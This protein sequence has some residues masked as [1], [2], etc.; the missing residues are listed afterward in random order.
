MNIKYLFLII[1]I[2]IIAFPNQVLAITGYSAL[3]TGQNPASIPELYPNQIIDF[4]VKFKNTGEQIWEGRGTKTVSLRTISGQKSKFLYTNWYNSYTPNKLN[5]VLIIGSNEES[6]FRFTLSAPNNLGMHWEKFNLFAGTNLISGGEIEI[7]IKV[8]SREQE[9]TA[10]TDPIIIEEEVIEIDPITKADPIIPTQTYYWQV[11]PSNI[12]IL[13]NHIW[14]TNANGPEIEIGLLFVEK[15]EKPDYLPFKISS[16]NNTSYDIYDQD[17]K[18]LVRNTSGELIEVDYDYSLN[19]YFLNSSDGQRILMTDSK[20]KLA[21]PNEE[22]IIF[23]I[24]SWQRGQFW[25]GGINDNEFRDKIEIKYNPNTERLWLVNE[26]PIEK[27]LRG[28]AEVTD[29][30]QSE[31]LKT[32]AIA[33]RTYAAFRLLTP[34]YTNTPD[35]NPFFTVR[36]TQADQVYRGYNKEKRAPNMLNAINLTKG[37]LAVYEND[38][39]LAYYFAQ[40]NGQTIASHQARMTNSPVN[41]LQSKIDPPGQGKQLIGHGVGLPQNSGITAASQGANYSQ[42]LKYYYSGIDL[43]RAY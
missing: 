28:L 26:L 39:I 14:P 30:T 16:L 12:N 8:V 21:S 22:E 29:N 43:N 19:R 7:G 5:P 31:F 15:Q 3:R 34:K 38:P 11:I 4:W 2:I 27:Y 41:Y 10:I 20:I 25:D 40:S 33:A 35:G 32:Q 1:F 17:N 24:D 36:A 18:L 37:I 6:I 23:K 42:I 9:V 13:N